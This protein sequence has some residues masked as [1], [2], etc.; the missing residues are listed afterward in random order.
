MSSA[1]RGSIEHF[2]IAD[3]FQFLAQ[4]RTTGTLEVDAPSGPIHVRFSEGSIVDAAPGG[5]AQ[6]EAG[7]L[8]VAWELLPADQLEALER[9]EET[10]NKELRELILEAQKVS[11]EE[12][13]EAE[14]FCTQETLFALLRCDRGSFQFNPQPVP[15]DRNTATLLGVEHIL[16][17]GLRM[18]DEW[19]RFEAQVPS[20]QAVF[21]RVAPLDG[22]QKSVGGPKD[23]R[24]AQ[25]ERIFDL[26]DGETQVARLVERSRLGTFD[27]TRL[28]AE[29]RIAGVID[30]VEKERRE[31]PEKLAV[32]TVDAVRPFRWMLGVAPAFGLLLM[33]AATYPQQGPGERAAVYS[34][35][36]TPLDQARL[37]FGTLRLRKAVEAFRFGE[38]RWPERLDELVGAGLVE[39]DALTASDGRPY[40]YSRRGDDIVLLAPEQ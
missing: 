11:A 20:A 33:I 19:S 31:K 26:V 34:I 6:S 39:S 21:E 40:Y 7:R 12:L 25:A 29:L 5:R 27:A 13:R 1:L 17:D 8:L 35:E 28:L 15:H 10:S 32:A 22:Y 30:V 2:G 36:T 4:Q 9:T 14:D 23:P 3:V 24:F 16:M 38:G 37:S 18:V